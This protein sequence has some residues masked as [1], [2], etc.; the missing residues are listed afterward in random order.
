MIERAAA[1]AGLG[2]KAY[3]HT[4][5]HACGYALANNR[6]RPRRSKGGS[7]IG[8]SPHGGL[9]GLGAEPVQGF[10]AV[11]ISPCLKRVCLMR[12]TH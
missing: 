7:A 1:S 9:H 5:R 8:R 4:L 11:R 6:P 3:P 10:L 2:L 12:L